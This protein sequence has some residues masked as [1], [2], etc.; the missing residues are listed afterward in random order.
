MMTPTC[1]YG[2]V[3]RVVGNCYDRTCIPIDQC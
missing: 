1:G 3:P 2:Q